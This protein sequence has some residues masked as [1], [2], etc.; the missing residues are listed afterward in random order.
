MVDET[1]RRELLDVLEKTKE[2]LHGGIDQVAR[3]RDN[4]MNVQKE[5]HGE[6]MEVRKEVGEVMAANDAVTKAYREAR[7][8]ISEVAPN[9]R[10]IL[11][12]KLYDEAERFMRLRV[13]FGDREGILRKRRDDLDREMARVGRV[14]DQS[15]SIMN[16]MRL[17]MEVIENQA[18]SSDYV[19][20]AG[21]AHT[22]DLAL[23]FAE[24]ENKRLAREIHDGPIQ[25]FAATVLSFEYLERVV[26]GGDRDAI[27]D[28]V[29][30]IKAQIRDTLGDFRGFLLQLQPVGLEKGLGRAIKRLA[31]NYRERYGVEFEVETTQEEDGF[32]GVLRSNMFR[33]VQEAVSNAMRHGKASK[34]GV[35]YGY[36]KNSLSLEI[37]DNGGGF[38]I[39]TGKALAAERGSYGLSNMNE[40]VNFVN[41]TLNIKSKKGHGTKVIIKAPIGGEANGQD[42]DSS[43]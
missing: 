5:L 37:Q 23:Q 14:A 38:D 33:V 30:R 25:Q 6:L 19:K 27:M 12:E 28:E 34:I 17:A 35:K 9:S 41:G 40:R 39:D 4:I 36:S 8:Q 15:V 21:D 43:G 10:N 32:S 26:A 7:S 24:R 2:S 31:E 11:N 20:T 13:S 42:Q 1:L 3:I 22:V 29:K 16:K 18:D